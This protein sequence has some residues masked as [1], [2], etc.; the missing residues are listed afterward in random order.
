LDFA[1]EFLGLAF[2]FEVG[3]VGNSPRFLFNVTFYFMEL[4]CDLIRRARFHVCSFSITHRHLECH[5]PSDRIPSVLCE[6]AL[7][8]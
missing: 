7:N 2:S 6:A 1:G 5:S 8:A 4:T 3:V